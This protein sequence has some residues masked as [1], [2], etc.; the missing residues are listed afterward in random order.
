LLE[1]FFAEVENICEAQSIS[2][3]VAED[4]ETKP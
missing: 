4:K 3:E 1:D 2:I